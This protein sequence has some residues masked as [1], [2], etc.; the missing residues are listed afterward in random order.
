[1]GSIYADQIVQRTHSATQNPDTTEY[2]WGSFY[3]RISGYNASHV[4]E[5]PM[6]DIIIGIFNPNNY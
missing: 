2:W 1:L 3:D 5:N 4:A 6:D